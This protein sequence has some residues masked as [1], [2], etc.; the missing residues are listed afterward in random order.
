LLK[1]IKVLC[2]VNHYFFSYGKRSYLFDFAWY[3]RVLDYLRVYLKVILTKLSL[4]DKQSCKYCGRD[5]HVIWRCKDE[6]WAKIPDKWHNT[7]LCLECFINLYP[8][9]L[10]TEDIEIVGYISKNINLK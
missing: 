6:D 2:G 8:E 10:K 9:N 1:P 7:A 3:F 5:Q 4:R